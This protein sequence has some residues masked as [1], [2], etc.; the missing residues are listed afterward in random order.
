MKEGHKFLKTYRTTPTMHSPHRSLLGPQ[1]LGA[2]NQ[3]QHWRASDTQAC[4]RLPLDA[5]PKPLSD[6]LP[7]LLTRVL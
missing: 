6:S 7:M 3:Q 2:S 1:K 5:S 4:P